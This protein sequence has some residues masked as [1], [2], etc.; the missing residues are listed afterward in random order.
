[1]AFINWKNTVIVIYLVFVLDFNSFAQTY[2]S[3]VISE[4]MANPN[5]PVGLP[6][7]EYVELYNRSEKA[8][9]LKNWKLTIGTRSA[10]FPD[11]VIFPGEYVLVCNKANADHLIGFGK[12]IPLSTFSLPNEDGTISIYQPGNSLVFSVS[13]ENS[14]WPSDKNAGGYSIEMIY[15]DNPCGAQNNWKVSE[16]IRGGTPDKINSVKSDNP[17]SEPPVIQR[18]DIAS[19]TELRIIA[20]EKLD[21]LASV[22]GTLIEIPGRKIVKR[23]LESPQFLNLLVTLDI[24]LLTNET[25][26]LSVRNLSDCAGNI[27]RQSDFTI[28]LPAIA[29]SGDVVL[30]E[31]LFNPPLGGVD[32]VEI[33]NRSKKYIDLKNWSLGNV[34][35]SQTDV[36]RIITTENYILPPFGYLALTTN[37]EMIKKLYPASTTNNFLRLTSLPAYSNTD[38]GVILKNQDVEIYD[39]FDYNEA[40]HDPLISDKKGVSLEKS[41]TDLSSAIISNWHSAS[42]VAGNATP[43]YANSQ[44]KTGIEND[45]FEIDPEAFAP[46]QTTGGYAR[47]KYKLSHSNKIATIKIFDTSGRLIRNLLRNQ[48]IGTLGEI[49]WDGRNENGNIVKTGYYLILIDIFDSN[50]EKTQYKRK[51]IVVQN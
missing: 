49:L 4:I 44:I 50:G 20:S 27:L 28:G 7:V 18:I 6:S 22:S 10:T 15:T 23:K 8:I 38:G 39:R 46:D 19:S 26:H 14:W 12:I 41:D 36:V 40:M 48:L 35:D 11:S 3:V 25:Y 33:Y 2:N 5:P 30:N 37:P 45:L 16:D 43:G 24:P 1:M 34:K 32:F 17:D 9:A 29:D 42:A 21:S 13:Y 51:V 47:I 31:I